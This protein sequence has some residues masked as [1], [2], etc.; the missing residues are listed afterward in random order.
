MG[1]DDDMRDVLDRFRNAKSPDGDQTRA[2]WEKMQARLATNPTPMELDDDEGRGAGWIRWGVAA[3]AVA[4]VIALAWS[5]DLGG[6]LQA[7]QTT[8][9]PDLEAPYVGEREAD[10]GYATPR[11]PDP[12]AKR[13]A[14]RAVE[15]E[16]EP[17]PEPEIVPEPEPEP[18][19]VPEPEPKKPRHRKP[20]PDPE[21]DPSPVPDPEPAVDA[22][23]AAEMALL[24][25][26]QQAI[27]SG[28]HARGLEK[29]KQHAK[30]FPKSVLAEEREL[31]RVRALCGL[32]KQ[33]AA[34]KA[35]TSFR[36]RFS[37]SHLV[38]RLEQTC[39]GP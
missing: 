32:G 27:A 7:Q 31:A 28:N 9:D 1:T 14:P 2:A 18:E 25:S 13:R 16:P 8:G 11:A 17:E 37:G 6:V 4:A 12:V 23:I 38:K 24:K 3:V 33:S 15:P 22:T 20:A 10:D 19:V 35:A 26:A 34:E 30:S 29:V 36:K 5:L 21:P 39:V